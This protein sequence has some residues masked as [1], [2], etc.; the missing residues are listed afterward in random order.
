MENTNNIVRQEITA[1][2]IVNG[3]KVT[4][5]FAPEAN[6]QVLKKAKNILAASFSQSV[7]QDGQSHLENRILMQP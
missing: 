6:D 2:F 4:M 1:R 3:S 5:K 7:I